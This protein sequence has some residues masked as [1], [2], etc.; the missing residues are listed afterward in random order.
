[1]VTESSSAPLA[2]GRVNRAV[3]IISLAVLKLSS[4]NGSNACLSP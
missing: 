3:D 2:V 1:M 4:T